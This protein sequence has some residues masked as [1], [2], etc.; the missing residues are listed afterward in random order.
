MIMLSLL[1]PDITEY[2][3]SEH[4]LRQGHGG[5]RVYHRKVVCEAEIDRGCQ[6]MQT[7][8]HK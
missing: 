4:Y 5:F 7:H 1:I 8:I 3:I 2:S 6:S